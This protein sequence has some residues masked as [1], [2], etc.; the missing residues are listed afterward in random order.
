MLFPETVEERAAN[1]VRLLTHQPGRKDAKL[2]WLIKHMELI[3]AEAA[4]SA[5]RDGLDPENT[6][7]LRAYTKALVLRFWKVAQVRDSTLRDW[8]CKTC[9]KRTT[10]MTRGQCFDCSIGITN[11]PV[12]IDLDSFTMP[13]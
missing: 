11:L 8:A 6:I 7:V 5:L 12:E 13:D 1:W 4:K 9:G 2:P 3:E 10:Q